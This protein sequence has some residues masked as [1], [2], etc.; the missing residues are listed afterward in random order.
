MTMS[1]NYIAKKEGDIYVDKY[2]SIHWNQ[3]IYLKEL[4]HIIQKYSL[5]CF[6]KSF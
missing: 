6:I 4:H 2:I 5:Q 1:T 3:F